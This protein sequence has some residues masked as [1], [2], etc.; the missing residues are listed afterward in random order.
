MEEEAKM[1]YG[2]VFSPAEKE[3]FK[4][5]LLTLYPKIDDRGIKTA[6]TFLAQQKSANCPCLVHS[7]QRGYEWIVFRRQPDRKI[8]ED[9]EDED[10]AIPVDEITDDEDF[11]SAEAE[12][13]VLAPTSDDEKTQ[14][15]QGIP[16]KTKEAAPEF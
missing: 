8:C 12:E 3:F 2:E 13:A 11:F 4:H 7:E 10:E 5:R 1:R 15:D 9:E 6:I 16:S 14:V